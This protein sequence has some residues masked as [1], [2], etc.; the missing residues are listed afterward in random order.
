[1]SILAIHAGAAY[2]CET[3]EGQRYRHFFDTLLRPEELNQAALASARVVIVPCRTP[4]ARLRPSRDLLL[5]FLR[6]GGTIVAM[7]ETLPH[8]WL[9]AIDFVPQPTNWWWWLEPGADLGLTIT[10]PAHA[11]FERIGPN[12]I[13]WHLHGSFRPPVGAVSL[14]DD[15]QGRSILYLDEVSTA[16]R[17]VIT[18]LDPFFHHGSHF[19]PATTRFLDGFLPWIRTHLDK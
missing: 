19:M 1:M 12:E 18:S 10:H 9:P 17:M 13:A 7:G 8:T 11:L 15:A 14:I 16:G 5:A 4:A 3:L 2:H 6:R